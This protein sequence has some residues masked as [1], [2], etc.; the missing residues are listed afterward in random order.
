[1]APVTGR[2]GNPAKP[3]G[4]VPTQIER[5]I[6]MNITNRLLAA[7]APLAILTLPAVVGVAHAEDVACKTN[8]GS[9][10]I[11]GTADDIDTAFSCGDLAQADQENTTAYGRAARASG[12]G[13]TAVGDQSSVI[14]DDGSA[15]GRGASVVA[16]NA[17]ALG[18][19]SVALRTD[20]VSIGRGGEE[21]QIVNLAAGTQPTDA[22]NVA[23]LNDAMAGAV[24]SAISSSVVGVGASGDGSLQSAGNSANGN[25]AVA[26]GQGQTAT[27]NGAV[28]IGDPNTATGTGAVAIGADNQALGDGAVALGNA[29]NAFGLSAIAIGDNAN[30]LADGSIAVGRNTIASPAS[31]AIGANAAA[32]GQ[33]AT[34]IGRDS[35]A[36]GLGT[37]AFGQNATAAGDFSTATGYGARA[38]KEGDT[39]TGS[40]AFANGG[41]SVAVGVNSRTT[42]LGATALGVNTQASGADS[43]AIGSSSVADQANT[44]SVG[45]VDFQRRIVNVAAGTAATDAA[46]VGQVQTVATA[47]AAAQTTADAAVSQNVIQDTEIAAIQTINTAQNGRLTSLESMA[48]TA[49]PGLQALT[50][51]HS[52]QIGQLFAITDRDR[53]EAQ[54]GTATAVALVAAPMPSE[55]GRTSYT[56]NLATFRG[57]Q[58]AG[59]SIAHRFNTD[60]AFAFTAGVSYAGSHN[61]AARIGVAGEF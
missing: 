20:S 30:A 26:L 57:E 37:A 46:N 53:R 11:A 14:T 58:A 15:F 16:T 13:A 18:A 44:V 48:G 6:D 1:M 31:V 61:T 23:Q 24:L 29:S 32:G 59:A 52:A 43:V 45:T 55:P 33:N 25:G 10:G 51:S 28:A 3:V 56:F 8:D 7:A 54:R 19:N 5:A 49:I 41:Y 39:A 47:A 2:H 21:R 17:V 27:G 50:A 38:I 42:G 12:S 9:D 40:G 35:L 36:S 60:N 22:V 4:T 34:A